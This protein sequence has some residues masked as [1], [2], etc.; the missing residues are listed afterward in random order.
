MKTRRKCKGRKTAKCTLKC[1]CK[2]EW[3]VRLEGKP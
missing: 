1:D 2:I 3:S